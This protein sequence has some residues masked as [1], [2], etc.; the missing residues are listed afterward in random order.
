MSPS[1]LTVE[2]WPVTDRGQAD[3]NQDTVLIYE[4]A[5]SN[6]IRFSGNLY[7]VADGLGSGE[8]G[9]LASEYAARRVM[10][11]Y[12]M[13]DEPDLGLRL[14]ESIEAA[15][16]DLYNYSQT[17]PQLVKIGATLVAAAVRG[18]EMHVASVGDSRAYLIR[19]GQIVQIT[20]DHTLV[21]QLIDEQAITEDEAKEHPRKDVV[22]RSLGSEENVRVD[23]HDFRLKPD[24]AL[25]LCS[26]GLT[27]YMHQD[28]IAQILATQSPRGAAEQLIR[29][30]LDRGGKENLSVIT[31]LLRDGAPPVQTITEHMWDGQP[32]SFDMQPTLLI[33]RTDV[34]SAAP[35]P[36]Q[37]V[38][39]DIDA[40]QFLESQQPVG[41][42]LPPDIPEPNAMPGDTMRH[43]AAY[44][45]QPSQDIPPQPPTQA[46]SYQQNVQPAP[47]YN[48]QNVQPAPQYGQPPQPY[49]PQNQQYGQRGVPRGMQPQGGQPQYAPPGYAIDPVTGLPPVPPEQGGYPPQPGY[50]QYGPR[51]YQP[52]AQPNAGR[53]RGGIPVGGF[54]LTGI[55]AIILTAIMVF[56]LVN[57]MNLAFPWSTEAASGDQA[58]PTTDAAAAPTTG[59]TP[60]VPVV[61]PTEDPAASTE[62]AAATGGGNGMVT[63]TPRVP[64]PA[65]MI[66]IDG[67]P[68]M[69]GVAEAEA[70]SAITVCI[71][72]SLG[73]TCNIEFFNDAEPVEEVT[74]SPYFIDITEVTN[75][76][77]A[78]CVAAEVC[79]VPD[80]IIF[81]NDPNYAQHPV[82]HV[83]Y[84][85]AVQFCTWAGKRLP[86]E[87]EWEKAARWDDIESKSFI[88]P[89]GD[90][91]TQGNANTLAAG[92][93]GTSAVRSWPNDVSPAG[94]FDMTGNV[95]EWVADWYLPDYEGLGTLNPIGPA[96]QPLADPLRVVRGGSWDQLLAL[97]RAGHR[98]V[99]NPTQAAEWLGFRCAQSVDGTAPG[100]TAT[101]AATE[102]PALTLPPTITPTQQP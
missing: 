85:K 20:R 94:I 88:F 81:Y 78:G 40:R 9:K 34:E 3:E 58:T 16:T 35:L 38:P 56:V 47:Q 13:H 37:T 90:D 11:H 45:T 51:V 59:I 69:R 79:T 50:P 92:Q 17:Q 10:H 49:A 30:T 8:R 33:R 19:D 99:A 84:A 48:Q 53:G 93:N 44:L 70:N 14:R 29:K 76:A 96:T 95:S 82:V 6:Q 63:A 83:S 43:P 101:S 22:L 24:D 52:P 102:T 80:N 67:G 74:L 64:V 7:V 36:N 68:F 91:F 60:T 72:E 15:N 62:E 12:Y 54:I 86:T 97:S 25:V 23:V 1:K 4:P 75:T 28:E 32:A 27:R 2:A 42:S 98:L 39:S 21:Q 46:P 41:T 71:Q 100:A 55:L 87:A 89:W 73:G 57:P 31:A 77:Y 18:E 61:A 66:L 26:D 5:N 65:G